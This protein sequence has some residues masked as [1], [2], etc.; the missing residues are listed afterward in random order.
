MFQNRRAKTLRI[1]ASRGIP[2]AHG[3]FETFAEHLAVHLTRKSWKVIVYCQNDLNWKFYTTEW[4][5]V[6]RIHIPSFFSGALG[7]F[8]YDFLSVI[9]VCFSRNLVLTFGYNTAIFALAFRLFN[10]F[11]IINMDGIEWKRKKWSAPIK[12]WFYV[13]E[14]FGL[15]LGNHLIADHP[16]IKLHLQRFVKRSAITMIPYFGNLTERTDRDLLKSFDLSVHG[17]CLIIAR[18][19]PE[20]MLFEMVSGFSEKKRGVALV[21]LGNYDPLNKYHRRIK[22]VASSEVR[23]PGA[24]Y[25]SVIVSTL[26]TYCLLYFHGHTVGGTNPSLVEAMAAGSPVLAHHNK[27]NRWVAGTNAAYFTNRVTFI[28]KLDN[29]LSHREI[30]FAM[31]HQIHRRFKVRFTKDKILERYESLLNGF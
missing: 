13:N 29:L 3:G 20:N 12:G 1:I 19:E 9:H 16:V 15:V 8:V 18:P 22:Q 2:A 28:E 26:R 31:G 30:I 27:F 21:V 25:D 14:L 23:F 10:V 11:N 5:G 6:K 4:K 17:F 24:I 7:T